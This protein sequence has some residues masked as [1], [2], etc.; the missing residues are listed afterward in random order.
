[1]EAKEIALSW[2]ESLE[3]YLVKKAYSTIYGARNLRR[4][5]QKEVEDAIANVLVER[6]NEKTDA[7]R[8]S[9]DGEKVILS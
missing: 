2:D 8:L 4:L 3:Q 5:I 6:R 7:I 9:S 1:M